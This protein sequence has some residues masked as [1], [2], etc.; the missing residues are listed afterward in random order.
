VTPKHLPHGFLLGCATAAHQVEGGIDNDW[1][2]W[3]AEHP[4]AIAGGGDAVIA[5]DHYHRYREDLAQ[6]QAMHQNAHRFSVEWARIEPEPGRFDGDALAHYADVVRTCRQQGMEPIV[7]LQ[8]FT[9]PV[10]L[11]DAGGFA[12]PEAAAR[13]A[14][15]VAVCVEA[16]GDMVTWWVTINEPTVVAVLGHLEG[17]WPPGEHSLPRT[18]AA[19]R[20]LLR[21][22]AAGAHAITAVSERHQRAAEVSIA[23]HERRL[24]PRD[25]W[26]RL[27]RRLA[28]VPDYV[29]NRWFLRSCAAGRSLGPIGDGS[30]IPGLAGSLTYLGLNHYA[31]EAVSFDPR[32]PGMLFTKHEA[33]PGYPVSSTGWAID[34]G[35]LRMAL[36]DLWEEF[37]LPIII[38]ENGV[39][40]EDDELRPAYLR[41]HLRAVVD[42]IDA[43]VDIRGYLLWTAWDNFEWAEGYT[44]KFGLFAV[45]RTTLERR[46][47]PSA[48]LYAEICRTLEIPDAVPTTGSEASPPRR[49]R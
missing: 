32:A 40:D 14:R 2:R 44:K 15:Y 18:I 11:A 36:S 8:H 20:G 45:D 39:A 37:R 48:A 22:H 3:T 29:F 7:T 34:P 19:L 31:N 47:K 10:W 21:M 9:L 42:A 4:E 25:P 6:L 35:A 12:A 17:A 43:G 13:F 16:F 46:P 28:I 27:E 30:V 23:H 1:S 33:V 26:S 49:R 5:I 38:T 41:D 24:V